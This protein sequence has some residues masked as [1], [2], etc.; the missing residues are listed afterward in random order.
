MNITKHEGK[1]YREVQRKAR[2]GEFIKVVKVGCH[3]PGLSI[4]DVQKVVAEC[5]VYVETNTRNGFYD[6]NSSEYIVLEP[7][8]CMTDEPHPE[9]AEGSTF[10]VV[11]DTDLY[12]F[13]TGDIIMLVEN[14]KSSSPWFKSTT[15]PHNCCYWHCISPLNIIYKDNGYTKSFSV[16]GETE[17]K[18]KQEDHKQ[19]VMEPIAR[20]GE[21]IKCGDLLVLHDDGKAYRAEPKK[22]TY[23]AEQIQEAKDIV[24]RIIASTTPDK[25]YA[26]DRH[27]NRTLC[28]LLSNEGNKKWVEI[29]CNRA[30]CSPNDEWQDDVGKCVAICKLTGE[31]MPKWV[32]GE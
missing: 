15:Y 30:K 25:A 9:I 13:R 1:Y 11:D 6:V 32:R 8:V 3:D 16:D 23:T 5:D 21:N 24:Y 22:R 10:V 31:P 28:R 19:I 27:S 7:I 29:G 20:A 18:P 12:T 17:I 14:D 26:F 4:G 2:K